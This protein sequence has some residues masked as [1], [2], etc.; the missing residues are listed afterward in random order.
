MNR[1]LFSTCVTLVILIGSSASGLDWPEVSTPEEAVAQ[2]AG[3]K[4]FTVKKKKDIQAE[5]SRLWKANGNKEPYPMPATFEYVVENFRGKIKDT[6]TCKVQ[7]QSSK[8]WKLVE[9]LLWDQP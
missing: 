1:S 9:G 5:G 4:K 3:T 7:Q 6:R 8:K 2:C